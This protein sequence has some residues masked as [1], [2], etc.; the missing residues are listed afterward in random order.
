MFSKIA[1]YSGIILFKLVAR[2][3]F[4]LLYF[5]SDI[6]NILV[7]NV[8]R[9]RRKTVRGNLQRSFPDY[10]A[11]KIKKIE[12]EY[13]R[14]LCDLILEIL[15]TSHLSAKEMAERMVIKNPDLVNGFFERGESV[16]ILAMHYGNWE[17]L[18]HMPL[19]LRHHPFFV[20]K[21]LQ[22]QYFDKYLNDVR[23]RFGGET[24]SMPLTL[25]KLIEAE[26]DHR[27][28]M[29]WLGADQTPPWNHPFWTVFLNQESM[30][31]N[32]PAKLAQRFN[33][34]VLF[35]QIKRIKRGF[36]ETSFEVLFQE[37][38]LV[39]EETIILSYVKKVES[40]I[41]ADPSCYLWSHK[42]WKHRRSSDTTVIY[43]NPLQRTTLL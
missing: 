36:Y 1:T 4:P 28:V 7:Y 18:L 12:K 43:A 30:F 38:R 27:L 16:I 42:R 14:F 37:P 11:L 23:E 35:Q 39:T 20:I 24:I 40:V 8:F 31:F 21:P 22:N 34:P 15:K 3:P 17:W 9:Y 25:R 19:Q 33:H 29:T 26:R 2:I 13:Y 10:G 32:G 6:L 41:Q 5:V